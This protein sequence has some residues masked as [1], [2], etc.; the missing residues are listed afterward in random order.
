[1]YIPFF[2]RTHRTRGVLASF[3][4]AAFL[5]SCFVVPKQALASGGLEKALKSGEK[6]VQFSGKESEDI[7]IPKGVTVTGD[8]RA[9]LNGEVTMLD[10]SALKNVTVNAQLFGIIVEKGA[11]V[12]LENV[13]VKGAADAGVFSKEGGGTLTIRNSKIIQN[14]KGLYIL[15]GKNIVISNSEIAR[16]KEEGIDVRKGVGGLISNNR[17]TDNGEG[18]AEIIAGGSSLAIQDNTFSANKASGLALQFY[19]DAKK[20]GQMRVENNTFSGNG[21]F[22]VVC[23]R[24]SGGSLPPDFF[25]NSVK[26]LS[27]TLS[28]NG[29]GAIHPICRLAN[30]SSQAVKEES[31]S[32]EGIVEKEVSGSTKDLGGQAEEPDKTLQ[33]EEGLEAIESSPTVT[34]FSDLEIGGMCKQKDASSWDVFLSGFDFTRY[35]QNI[36]RIFLLSEL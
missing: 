7:K 31:V 36:G 21:N 28:G 18:G 11:S 14:R 6:S 35:R 24:P 29:Q 12:T 23:N 27:N 32:Q 25:R 4:V 5:L 15:P 16:N 33:P 13:T 8:G 22:G 26:L 30:T 34:D 17:I 1:M 2:S 9:T 19:P 3:F 20:T 10:G